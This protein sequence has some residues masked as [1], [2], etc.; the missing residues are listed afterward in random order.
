[1]TLTSTLFHR[2]V[3]LGEDKLTSPDIYSTCPFCESAD[4]ELVWILQKNPEVSLL[5]CNFCYAVSASRMPTKE[6][7]SAYYN[8]YYKS[9]DN[10]GNV[11]QV[12]FD[13]PDRLSKQIATFYARNRN[14]L[15]S[16]VS[17][18][19]F[20]GGDGTI[21]FLTAENLLICGVQQVNIT[22]VD[23]G[24]NLHKT[25]N[26][27]IKLRKVPTLE[28]IDGL[29]SIVIA[30][31][32]LEHLP[33]PSNVIDSLLEFMDSSGGIFYARTP[34]MLPV[35]K[36]LGRFG[37]IIDF[38]FPAHLHDLGQNFWETYFKERSNKYKLVISRP[39]IVETSIKKHFFRTLIAYFLKAPWYL[40]RN[41][42]SLVGGW[43][44]FV[45]R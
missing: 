30:S 4:R 5:R 12:T 20:G 41:K 33:R 3:H 2:S 38:T 36:F 31:A 9:K 43:E 34:F 13:N 21:A 18:L 24:K 28:N 39:S 8:V 16:R 37:I 14:K 15:P 19:D 45:E 25:S 1:M 40:F 10:I 17:I 26:D 35:M 6:A 29:Y 27:R 7:L 23:Y 22:V 42:Y 11:I 32:I 44:I